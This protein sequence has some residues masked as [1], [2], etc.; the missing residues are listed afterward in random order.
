[1]RDHLQSGHGNTFRDQGSGVHERVSCAGGIHEGAERAVGKARGRVVVV[2]MGEDRS[3]NESNEL[4]AS[5]R[6]VKGETA[7]V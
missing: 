5:T 1:M 4:V 6:I 7:I 3:E 2:Q